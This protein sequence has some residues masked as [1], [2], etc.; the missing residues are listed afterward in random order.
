MEELLGTDKCK[1]IGV[2]NYTINHLKE[3]F[4]NSSVKPSLN[5]I[6]FNPFVFQ[7]ELLNFCKNL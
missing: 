1:A 4:E 6:E 3:L 7:N 2:S 5:Q